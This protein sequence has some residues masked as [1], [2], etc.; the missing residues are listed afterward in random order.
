MPIEFA[1]PK[2]VVIVNTVQARIEDGV[3][4]P[5][6]ALPSET[7]LMG[8]FGVSRPT[9]VRALE[10]LRRDGWIESQQGKGRFVRGKPTHRVMPAHAAVLLAG[11]VDGRVR[12]VDARQ[13][14]APARVAWALGVP[15]GAPVMLRRWM[16]VVDGVGPVELCTA[17]VPPQVARGT[18]I[19]EPELLRE[20]LMRHLASR[21]QIQFDQATQR[22]SARPATTEESRLL[23]VARRACMLT[24]LLTLFDRQRRA[25]VTLDVIMPPSRRELAD[26]FS[27]A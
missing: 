11:E 25:V 12:L 23:Q 3:Y 19:G 20:G 24:M 5:G 27:L 7:A 8:E 1:P 4:G 6:A 14:R 13:V 17:Y 2:Y 26:G 9:V 15:E 22:I 10:M 16:T 21:K 18:R